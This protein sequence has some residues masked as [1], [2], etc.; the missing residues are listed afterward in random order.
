[1][2]ANARGGQL[3]P[4]APRF[5]GEVNSCPYE[6]VQNADVL[7]LTDGEC[8][9]SEQFLAELHTEQAARR[10]TVT[11]ILMDK[12]KDCFDF[13]LQPFCQ[14]IYRTSELTGDD[15]VRAVVSERV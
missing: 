11:G 2:R 14:K 6:L 9:L 5:T 12:G 4:S 3:P 10:F 8:S 13:S 7:F 15:A 1:M